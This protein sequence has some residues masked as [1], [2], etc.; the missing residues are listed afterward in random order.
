M[1]TPIELALTSLL[2]THSFL[3]PALIDLATSLLSQSRLKATHLKPE[4][5]IGRTYAC[6]HI[7]CQR[8]G[9]KLALDLGKPVPP[10]QPKVYDKLHTYLGTVLK[11]AP[12]TPRRRDGRTTPGTGRSANEMNTPTTRGSRAR[13]DEVRNKESQDERRTT[14]TPTPTVNSLRKRKAAEKKVELPEYTMPLIRR[15]CKAF[16]VPDAAPHVNAGVGSIVSDVG[17]DAS[18]MPKRRKRALETESSDPIPIAQLPVLITALLFLVMSRM[19]HVNV[20]HDATARRDKAFNTMHDFFQT[21]GNDTAEF[22]DDEEEIAESFEQFMQT[23]NQTWI[24][25]EWYSNVPKKEELDAANES[26]KD[27]QTDLRDV[28]PS[29]RSAKTPLRRN[30]KHAKT[31]DPDGLGAAG[32]LP[33]LGTMFQPAVDWLSDERLEEYA[34]WESDVRR[35][36]AAVEI[37]G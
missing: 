2:P 24:N 9:R 32:L 8:L 30:E 22:S 36:I 33:G 15:V 4:E 18:P 34:R 20:D 25:M 14:P 27:T 29:A 3:P 28:I 7:A 11:S 5:E 26:S 17:L 10:C 12:Q 19:H 6:C 23:G 37:Q 16:K 13:V 1:P 35:Q 21:L 31:D